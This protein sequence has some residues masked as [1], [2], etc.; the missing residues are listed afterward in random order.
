MFNNVLGRKKTIL[1]IKNS[2][3]QSP[4]KSHFSKGVIRRFGQKM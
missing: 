3:F 2:I 4:K 1:A